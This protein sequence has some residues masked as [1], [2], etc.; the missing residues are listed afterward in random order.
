MAI[1]VYLSGERVPPRSGAHAGPAHRS[2]GRAVRESRP[3]MSGGQVSE[4]GVSR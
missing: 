2:F 1:V 4:W 3:A